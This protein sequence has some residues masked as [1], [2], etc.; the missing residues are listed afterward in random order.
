ML[1][2]FVGTGFFYLLFEKVVCV[3]VCLSVGVFFLVEGCQS[4]RILEKA[5]V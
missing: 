4:P 1:L 5:L 3:C 2:V